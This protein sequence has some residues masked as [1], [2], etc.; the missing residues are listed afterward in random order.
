M[1][2]LLLFLWLL[3][4][5]LIEFTVITGLLIVDHTILIPSTY[6]KF[7]INYNIIHFLYTINAANGFRFFQYINFDAYCSNDASHTH[8]YNTQGTM[9]TIEVD[10]SINMNTKYV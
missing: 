4:W 6:S 3:F 7:T 9:Q 2:V 5:L 8:P 10:I 1:P